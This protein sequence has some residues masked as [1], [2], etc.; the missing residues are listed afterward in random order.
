M[1]LFASLLLAAAAA[2]SSV[3]ALK[4]CCKAIYFNDMVTAAFMN[5]PTVTLHDESL[6][7]GDHPP[8]APF[9]TAK[10][11]SEWQPAGYAD[12]VLC[13]QEVPDHT[14]EYEGNVNSHS[15]K[16]GSKLAARSAGGEMSGQMH[17]RT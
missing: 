10:E 8:A 12:T 1:R 6:C 14:K 13:C 17:K 4:Y 7:C 9:F 11:V 2:S 16:C 5:S 3:Q 15:V